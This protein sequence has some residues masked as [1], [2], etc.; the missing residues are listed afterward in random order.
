MP[1]RTPKSRDGFTLIELMMT[2]ALIGILAAIAIP[3]FVSYQA[4]S[5]RSEAFMNLTAISRAQTTYAAE[6][7][8]Y[9]G[10]SLPWPDYTDTPAGVLGTQKM[11]WT[12]E[13]EA[14]F[15]QVGWA[16]EGRVFYAYE[17]NTSDSPN[18]SCTGCFTA[19]AFGDVDGDGLVSAVMYV[20]PTVDANGAVT[21]E[22]PSNL[23]EFGTPVDRQTGSPIY[24]QVA[25]QRS[26][27]EY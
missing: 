7:D 22:C 3:N 12:A 1:L 19:S 6:R 26:T 17:I 24:D 13:S 14:A 25:V 27:D 5:R 21:G 10:T 8:R 20:H 16:P 18:C 11:V 23:L 2:V 4:R 15:S 9:H